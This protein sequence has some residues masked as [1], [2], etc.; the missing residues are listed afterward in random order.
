MSLALKIR[1]KMKK[2][3]SIQKILITS[4]AMFSMIFG[5]GNFILPPLLGIKAAD[6]WDVVAIAFGI[7]GVLIPLMGII[8]QAKIQGTVIDF[9]KKVHPVFAL[10]IGILI[11]GICLSFPIPRTASVAYEL[12]VKDSIEISSLWF[13]VIYFSLV[14][15][16]CFNRGKILDI[17]GEYLTPILLIIILTIILGAVFFVDNEIPKSNLEKP[18]SLGLLEGYQ[19][20]DGMASIIIGAVI[21][22]SLNM[23]NSLD[24]SQK[25]RLTIYAGLIS[26]LALFIIYSGFIYTGAVLKSHFPSDDLPRSEVLSKVSWYILGDIGKTLLSVSVSIAC[27]TTAVGIITGAADFMKNIFGNSEMVYKLVVVFSCILGVFVGQTGV[28]NIVSIAVP[29]LVLIYPVIMALI[30]LNFVPE[31]WTSVS[32]FRGVTLVAGIFAIPDFMISIGF[33]SFKPL[34]DYLPLATYG[35]AWLLPCLVIWSILFIFQK[36]KQL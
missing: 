19:T 6:S 35:L 2:K 27:F 15:Y 24:F 32:I 34:H 18:F 10:V 13:G 7:S 17:L 22:T 5:G 29:V 14:M 30:L 31:S 36:N 1:R 25:R 8:A 28:E 11:Y 20:F 3:L 4:F 33:E 23:D 21:I 9:G 12:S 26:G 16:L